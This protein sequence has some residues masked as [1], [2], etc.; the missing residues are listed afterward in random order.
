MA[1]D[2]DGLTLY[3][4]VCSGNAYKPALM[5]A[6]TETLLEFSPIELLDSLAVLIPPP[7]PAWR[8]HLPHRYQSI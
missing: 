2:R 3:E 7:R 5:M 6:L 1:N 4:H 8:L